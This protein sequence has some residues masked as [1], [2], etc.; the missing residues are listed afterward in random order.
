MLYWHA[1][2]DRDPAHRWFREQVVAVA[3]AKR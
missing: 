3:G 2:V 1:R